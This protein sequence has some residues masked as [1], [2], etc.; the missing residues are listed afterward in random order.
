MKI[1]D[2]GFSE[3]I[4]TPNARTQSAGQTNSGTSS[5]AYG[6]SDSADQ[7]QLSNLASRLQ[8]TE[9][10]DATR[11]ARLSQIAQAVQ[12]NSFHVDSTQV[13]KAIVSEAI[14]RQAG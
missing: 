7:W 10:S 13:S 6:S 14:G 5:A 2:N 4:T 8:T 9:A 12:S 3:R 1:S 11:A